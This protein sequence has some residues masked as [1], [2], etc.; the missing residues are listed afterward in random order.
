MESV[1]H[2]QLEFESGF[3]E[4]F[5]FTT[6]GLLNSKYKSL[7][8]HTFRKSCSKSIFGTRQRIKASRFYK[9]SQ[10]AVILKLAVFAIPMIAWF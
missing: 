9:S 2:Q 8:R 4:R 3:A 7:V 5:H 10:T 6:Q 1:R